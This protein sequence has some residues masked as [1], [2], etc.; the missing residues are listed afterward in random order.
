MYINLCRA[1]YLSSLRVLL[2]AA[3]PPAIGVPLCSNA[4]VVRPRL[5]S[6]GAGPQ[7]HALLRGG[8]HRDLLRLFFQ[9]LVVPPPSPLV[10]LRVMA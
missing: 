8:G 4:C 7:L 1:F 5:C 3:S 6:A 10:D 9:L 2:F